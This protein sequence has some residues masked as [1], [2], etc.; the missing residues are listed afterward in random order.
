[1]EYV[2]GAPIRGPLP[3][4]QALRLA[5]QVAD[6]LELAHSKKIIH[7]DLKPANILLTSGGVKLLDFGLA[8]SLEKSAGS[9]ADSTVT[10]TQ[11]GTVLGT[12]AYMAPEQAEGRA[13]DARSDIFS[14][15]VVLYEILTGR[16]AFSGD[17]AISTMAAV[18]HKEPDP[19]DAP[20]DVTVSGT[21]RDGGNGIRP[22]SGRYQVI[23]EYG[24]TQPK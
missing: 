6:A 14:F 17:T 11:A 4:E 5:Q 1:M 21:V 23:D 9:S 2:D 13:A 19:L 7:R 15:G 3:P 12:A 18:L 8:K 10:E 20:A 16:R 24:T 22:G